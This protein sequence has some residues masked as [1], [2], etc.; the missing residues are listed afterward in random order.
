[1]GR[2]WVGQEK[3]YPCPHTPVAE[4]AGK[5]I[6]DLLNQFFQ[7]RGKWV[8]AGTLGADLRSQPQAA[9]AALRPEQEGLHRTRRGPLSTTGRSLA[10]SGAEKTPVRDGAG[11]WEGLWLPSWSCTEVRPTAARCQDGV[12]RNEVPHCRTLT[13]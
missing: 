1:M 4:L 5:S 9:G 7:E 8:P 13:C 6:S 2:V 11:L 10:G 12:R 3:G